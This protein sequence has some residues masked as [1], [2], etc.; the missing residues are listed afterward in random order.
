[1][2]SE[3]DVEGWIVVAVALMVGLVAGWLIV[4]HGWN[5]NVTRAA[6]YSVGIFVLLAMA[7]RPAWHRLRLWVDL[8]ILLVLHVALVL[9]LVTFL[10]SQ[11]IRLN[12]AIALPFIAVELLLALSVLWRRNVSGPLPP[13]E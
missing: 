10:D 1:M 2:S 6:A 8:V 7:L 13:H 3:P 12:W 9:P 5:E 11:S 4:F